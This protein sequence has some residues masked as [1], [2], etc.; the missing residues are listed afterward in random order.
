M[1]GRVT[2]RYRA[3]VLFSMAVF[4]F[5][6]KNQGR[7]GAAESPIRTEYIRHSRANTALGKLVKVFHG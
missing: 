3:E 7:G 1:S 6:C 4:T 5:E 2:K